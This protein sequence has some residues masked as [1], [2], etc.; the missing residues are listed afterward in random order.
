MAD[1][2]LYSAEAFAQREVMPRRSK[3][4]YFAEASIQLERNHAAEAGHLAARNIMS[5]MAGE[6][7]K[8]NATDQR[9]PMERIGDRR[10]ILFVA[11]HS[12]L[13]RLQAAHG[14]PTIKRRRHGARGILQKLDRL[15]HRPIFRQCGPL[16]GV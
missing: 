7:R 5:R 12:Q 8:V 11:L 16:H 14:E 4:D 1:Q 3:R 9:M 15:E 2:R 13:K 10:S 6:T